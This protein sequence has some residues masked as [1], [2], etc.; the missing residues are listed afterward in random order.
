MLIR[1]PFCRNAVEVVHDASSEEVVC[2]LC[3]SRF[4]L[5]NDLTEAL[6]DSTAQQRRTFSHFELID[7][8][9]TGASGSVWK[10]RDTK[11]DRDV[12]V[13]IA[14]TRG[15]SSFQ[16]GVFLQRAKIAHLPH[17]NIVG[18]H[19]IGQ[20]DGAM[21]IVTDLLKGVTLSS[22]LIDHRPNQKEAAEL[23]IKLADALHFAHERG[24]LH[25]DL[26]PNNIMLDG[27]S[28]PHIVDFNLVKPD[29]VTMTVDGRI[30]STLAY[31][32][33]EQATGM[34]HQ[35]DRRS[36]IYSL[37]VILFELL[38]G[39]RPFRGDALDVLR[40]IVIEEPPNPRKLNSRIAIEVET[41]CLHCMEKKP[42]NRYATAQELSDDLRRWLRKE[43]IKARPVGTLVRTMRWCRR[44]PAV[45]GFV[46]LLVLAVVALSVA[47]AYV[48]H[49]QQH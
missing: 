15:L 37:G 49:A 27:N 42:H 17:P 2:P 45:S 32:S 39:E 12:A 11:L 23:C 19:E 48:I 31:L 36:D 44:N 24:F 25:R 8:L 33:P 30:L 18:V 4:N 9:G 6:T 40:Q 22:W 10:A 21:Y 5:I 3:G 7:C 38:T 26:K 1:C 29:L 34:G 41:M 13:K 16:A 14:R 20:H 28:E 47:L 35:V 46:A 43:P